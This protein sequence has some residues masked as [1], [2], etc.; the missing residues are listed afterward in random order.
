MEKE[1]LGTPEIKSRNEKQ[2]FSNKKGSVETIKTPDD[3]KL[4]L[5]T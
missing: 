2:F 3:K 4:F 1:K 5:A